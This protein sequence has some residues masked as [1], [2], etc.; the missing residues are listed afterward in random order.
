[1][2]HLGYFALGVLIAA[3]L[4]VGTSWD[5]LNKPLPAVHELERM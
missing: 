5:W 3:V 1:M 2:R 4:V